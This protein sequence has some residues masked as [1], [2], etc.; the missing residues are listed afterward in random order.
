LEAIEHVWVR[1]TADGLIAFEGM[2]APGQINAWSGEE[3]A[4]VETGNGAGLLVTANGLPQRAMC[5]RGQVCTRTWGPDGEV[6][7]P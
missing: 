3:T 1:V 4:T 2:M 7:T 5:E 6:T